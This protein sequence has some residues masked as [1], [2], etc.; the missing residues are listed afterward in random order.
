MYYDIIV[1]RVERVIIMGVYL[2]PNNQNFYEAVNKEIYVDK[3]LLIERIEYLKE[4]VNS[5][6]YDMIKIKR[7]NNI[8][9]DKIKT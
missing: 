1:K 8:K 2:N 7:K 5:F 3:S 4:K 6:I 9:Y